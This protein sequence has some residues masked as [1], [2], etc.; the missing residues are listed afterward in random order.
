MRREPRIL[1]AVGYSVAVIWVGIELLTFRLRVPRDPTEALG[2]V[3][4]AAVA[5]ALAL[6]WSL[7]SIWSFSI[8]GCKPLGPCA[9]TGKLVATLCLLGTGINMGLLWWWALRQSPGR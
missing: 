5:F 4:L 1:L 2:G 8:V 7:P 3:F 9:A 6:P